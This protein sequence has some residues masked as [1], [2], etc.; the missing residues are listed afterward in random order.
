M[1]SLIM[2]NNFVDLINQNRSLAIELKN[3][4]KTDNSKAK[5]YTFNLL[6]TFKRNNPQFAVIYG[7]INYKDNVGKD[8]MKGNVRVMYGNL[9]LNFIFGNRKNYVIETLRT[10]FP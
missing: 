7:A 9:L 8:T 10:A 2:V 5:K 6:E 4:W 3:S 1:F